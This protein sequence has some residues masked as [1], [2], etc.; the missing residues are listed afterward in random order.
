MKTPKVT[1]ES[2][3]S[4]RILATQLDALYHEINKLATKKPTERI[5]PLIAKKIN[6]L[7]KRVKEQV[8]G[9]EFLD[10]IETV[11]VEND[12][13]RLDE[14]LIILGELRT[15]MDRQWLSAAFSAY[16]KEAG[17]STANQTIKPVHR[18]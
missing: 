17:K 8:S 1:E 11:P 2:Y 5:T 4:H 13:L 12:M 18:V 16:R 9:D 15:I 10:A 7:I 6:H 3:N 14:A